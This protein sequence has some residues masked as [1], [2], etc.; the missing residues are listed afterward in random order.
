MKFD[1]DTAYNWEIDQV[2][3]KSS[4]LQIP[5]QQE[6]EKKQQPTRVTITYNYRRTT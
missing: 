3:R 1:E 6:E 5:L 4:N 2:Q